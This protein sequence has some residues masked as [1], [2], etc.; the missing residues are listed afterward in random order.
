MHM[1]KKY[2]CILEQ[3]TLTTTFNTFLHSDDRNVL[4]KP[5]TKQH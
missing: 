2:I 3:L 5:N 4:Q 1:K